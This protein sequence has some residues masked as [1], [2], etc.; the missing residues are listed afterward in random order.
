RAR[1]ELRINAGSRSFAR[2]QYHVLCQLR[3]LPSFDHLVGAG[4]Q[5]W[6]HGE[7]ERLGSWKIDHEVKLGR[8]LHWQIARRRAVQDLVYERGATVETPAQIDAVTDQAA[9]H[10]V[11]AISVDS[12]EP[13]RQRQFGNS[14]TQ[15]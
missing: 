12:G 2:R 9:S 8:K 13:L 7:A 6:R 10:D 14:P 4:E 5:C 3:T 11:L 1:R 15:V